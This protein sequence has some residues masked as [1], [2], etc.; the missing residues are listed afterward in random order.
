MLIEGR[1]GMN[2]DHWTLCPRA[3]LLQELH[4]VKFETFDDITGPDTR[5]TMVTDG[6]TVMWFGG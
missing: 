3:S 5:R 4:V 2:A 6:S 1:A